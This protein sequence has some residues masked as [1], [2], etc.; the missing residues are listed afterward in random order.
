MAGICRTVFAAMAGRSL[1]ISLLKNGNRQNGKGLIH[2]RSNRSSR[3]H[4]AVCI[5]HRYSERPRR[6]IFEE[7]YKEVVKGNPSIPEKDF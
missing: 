4:G 6:S 3:K 2:V 1:S 5:M 7:A